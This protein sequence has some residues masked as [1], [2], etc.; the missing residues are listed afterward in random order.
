MNVFS[1][2]PYFVLCAV[3][4]FFDHVYPENL[5]MPGFVLGQAIIFA[6][7]CISPVPPLFPFLP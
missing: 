4:I 6:F 2:S 3:A 5:M 7:H 1:L